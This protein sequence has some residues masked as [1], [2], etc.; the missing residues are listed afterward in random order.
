MRRLTRRER[1]LALICGI[2]LVLVILLQGVA[3]PL[4]E[5][6]ASVNRSLHQQDE[7]IRR[8]QSAALGL[9]AIEKDTGALSTSLDALVI[10][11][12]V[13]PEMMRKVGE[14]AEKAHIGEVDIRPLGQDEQEGLLRH[15]MQLEVRLSFPDLKNFLYFLEEGKNPLIID[16]LE[17]NA[18]N[19]TSDS[20]HSSIL[21]SAYSLPA[22]GKK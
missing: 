5:R 17:V 19:E 3:K 8:A 11:G 16:R 6:L 7:V 12:E 9:Y 4:R 13:I 2:L 18:E 1:V 14:A 20:V 10:S 22:G 21:V 15:R